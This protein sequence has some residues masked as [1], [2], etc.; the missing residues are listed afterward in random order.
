MFVARI[1]LALATLLALA[2]VGVLAPAT[3]QDTPRDKP[4]KKDRPTERGPATPEVRGTVQSV[5]T[6]K[7][8]VTVAIG[9]RGRG[10]DAE[11]KTF[12][13]GKDAEVLLDE[14]RGRR[15]AFRE[16]K[17][18]DLAAGALVTLV[19]RADG[20]VVET[21]LAEGPAFLGVV[22]SVD[23]AKGTVTLRMAP[24]GRGEDG[25]EKTFTTTKTTE[26]AVD[27]GRGRRFSIKEGMLADVKTGALATVKLSVDQKSVESLVAEGPNVFG[28]IKGVDT[29][30]NT[31]TLQTRPAR[32]DESAE[33]KTFTLAKDVDVLVDESG[34]RRGF[35]RLGK[36]TD[37]KPGAMAGVKL[38]L[39]QKT[40][41][42][43]RVDG[44]TVF[45]VLKSVNVPKGTVTVLVGAGRGSDGEEK[46]FTL[47]KGARVLQEGR[48][49]NLADL[50][51]GDRPLV[52]VKLSVDQ[53]VVR[54][55]TIAGRRERE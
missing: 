32:G 26:I 18:A 28:V 27:D 17:F 40:A 54:H 43:V 20:K 5:D 16:G 38:S 11:Q 34:G 8:T 23:A 55:I 7:S 46:T 41:V 4:V 33:E 2:A 3:A 22:K 21:I 1:R 12:T 52:G 15:F 50:K 19:L 13:V 37:L 31:L 45:G 36:Q 51:A 6:A 35:A 48:V 30:G 25:E 29:S 14:G 42:M 47:G 9:A 24:R 39:D 53:K 10:P 49:I 44:P